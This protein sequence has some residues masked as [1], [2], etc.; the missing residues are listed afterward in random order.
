M[1]LMLSVS[2]LCKPSKRVSFDYLTAH[3]IRAFMRKAS[4]IC[5]SAG[6]LSGCANQYFRVTPVIKH[7]EENTSAGMRT[8]KQAID[9]NISPYKELYEQSQSSSPTETT[10]L[11]ATA[12]RNILQNKIIELSDDI[13]EQHKGDIVGTASTFN[14]TTG[15]G[16][17]IF[18]GV[19]AIVTGAAAANYAAGAT[20]LNGARSA[21]SAEVY[22]G[23]FTTAIIKAIEESRN[24]KRN[25]ISAKQ[26][27]DAGLY[28]ADQAV[29]D[30]QDY[31][32]RCSFYHGLVVLNQ[33]S[34]KRAA[35]SRE[36][37]LGRIKEM[38]AEQKENITHKSL[39]AN[40]LKSEPTNLKL[41]QGI[42]AIYDRLNSMDQY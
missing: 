39:R 22:Q 31:H 40:Q 18:S 41:E 38:R 19:S 13:C 5:L 25:E 17:T 21:V 9:L 15:L 23:L 29:I 42:N 30:A 14:L 11:A 3:T 33:D 28:S 24:K 10:H 37:L 27:K 12:S 32:F 6:L 2:V 4:L 36:E 26:D 34:K 1:C 35:P 20:I 8:Q 7:T 16:A